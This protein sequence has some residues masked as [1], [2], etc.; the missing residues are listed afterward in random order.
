[1]NKLMF[2]VKGIR[3]K[4]NFRILK[5][6][7]F[8][9]KNKLLGI[10]KIYRRIIFAL[11]VL[12]LAAYLQSGLLNYLRI[13]YVKPDI[14]LASLVLFV[15]FFDLR[16]LLM[17]AFLGGIFCD[18]FSI[19][20]FGV[21]IIILIL[22]IFLAY[23]L[24]RKLSVENQIIRYTLLLVII[25]LK[26]LVFGLTFFI[27]DKPIPAVVFL[28]IAFLESLITLLLAPAMHKLFLCLL[29]TR[30]EELSRKSVVSD[31]GVL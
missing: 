25:L 28:R 10:F 21:N 7:F 5:Y 29:Q 6:Y 8:P 31:V 24:T 2:F 30:Q 3:K 22:C 20:P 26:N 11:L 9:F 1:M 17:F 12:L 16:Q 13:F 15:P 18:I 27:L 4:V 14:I 19:L 23:K